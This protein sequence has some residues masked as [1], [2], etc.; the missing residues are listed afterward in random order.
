MFF[1]FHSYDFDAFAHSGALLGTQCKTTLNS[2]QDLAYSYIFPFTLQ[3]LDKI[4][5]ILASHKPLEILDRN[6]GNKQ[7]AIL[8]TSTLLL[9]ALPDTLS[10]F[11]V[12]DI[13]QRTEQRL[14]CYWT[15]VWRRDWNCPNNVIVTLF[16][17]SQN[18]FTWKTQRNRFCKSWAIE[19]LLIIANRNHRWTTEGLYYISEKWERQITL[20][21][22]TAERKNKQSGR[23]FVKKLLNTSGYV[24]IL[25]L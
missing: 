16:L 1:T 21:G 12:L 23:I 4:L 22:S 19:I 14:E 5:F 11:E 24:D 6:L 13:G 8:Y 18:V 15:V 20:W 7:T 9:F 17:H 10:F 3:S 25:S 2:C